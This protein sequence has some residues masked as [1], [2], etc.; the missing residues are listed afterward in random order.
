VVAVCGAWF[1]FLFISG[2]DDVAAGLVLNRPLGGSEGVV[3]EISAEL[4]AG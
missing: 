4:W 2:F 1:A 3:V